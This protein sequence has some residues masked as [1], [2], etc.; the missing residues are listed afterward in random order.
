VKTASTPILMVLGWIG[1]FVAGQA[2]AQS[3]VLPVQVAPAGNMPV[4]NGPAQ[5]NTPAEDRVFTEGIAAP[6]EGGMLMDNGLWDGASVGPGCAICGGGYSAPPD[7]YVEEGVRILTRSRP[8]G[9][10]LGFQ[11][12]DYFGRP[13]PAISTRSVNPDIS[14]AWSTTIG[15][16][17]A[18]D[19]YDRDHFV[20]FSFWGLNGWRDQRQVNGQ[21]TEVFAGTN[22]LVF[23]SLNS[24]D[25]SFDNYLNGFN[26][27]DQQSIFYASYTNNFEIN[28]RFAPRGRTDR[29]VLHPDGRW[30]RECQPGQYMSYLYGLR[31]MQINETFN[32]HSQGTTDTYSPDPSSPSGYTLTDSHF[33]TGDYDAVAHNN[34]LGLQIGVEM[35]FRQCRWNWGIHSKLSPC[36]N[37]SD[38][39]SNINSTDVTTGTTWFNRQ[40]AASKHEASL[41]GEVGFEAT[42]KFRPNLMGR[43]AYD[44]TWVTGLALAPE[45]LQ[46]T[47]LPVNKINTNGTLFM[48]GISLGLE[49]LW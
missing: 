48:H 22:V 41:I 32:F 29:L 16:Y 44:F 47:T 6:A 37:F 31:F 20:E 39:A 4:Q 18:R 36:V 17:F 33:Y 46:M 13:L 34:L 45:Q 11:G 19:I 2:E 23:G 5:G 43:A 21:R 3:P 12:R 49:W 24:L 35:I 38:Q 26:R 10:D 15:H 25:S 1:L 8:R 14:A 28:G 42:F 27:A 9:I 40:I 7:W 30:R